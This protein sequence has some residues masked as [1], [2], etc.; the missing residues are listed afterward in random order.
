MTSLGRICSDPGWPSRLEEF[1]AAKRKKEQDEK[2]RPLVWALTL[3]GKLTKQEKKD[4]A[5]IK[6]DFLKSDPI[7]YQKVV[8]WNRKRT[9][10]S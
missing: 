1:L 7:L 6:R 4:R 10:T 3:T 9:E 8:K 5:R 2:V